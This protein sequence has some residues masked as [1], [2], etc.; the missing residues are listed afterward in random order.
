MPDECTI[1]APKG[2][3]ISGA[4]FLALVSSKKPTNFSPIFAPRVENGS[5]QKN[6][7][8]VIILDAPLSVQY[9]VCM[10]LI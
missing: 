1:P 2:Q 6:K 3:E 5:N 10:F 9:R 8:Q 4:N 7:R